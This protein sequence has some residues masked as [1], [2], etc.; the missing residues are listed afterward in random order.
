MEGWGDLVA[1]LGDVEGNVR[2]G[3]VGGGVDE[4]GGEGCDLFVP[5]EEGF[6]R[7][8]GW[9]EVFFVL[10]VGVSTRLGC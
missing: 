3:G 5:V 2:V 7:V 6:A 9:G 4:F 1:H 8:E 10:G